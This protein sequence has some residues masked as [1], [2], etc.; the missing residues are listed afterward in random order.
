MENIFVN[1]SDLDNDEYNINLDF[2]RIK[3]KKTAII[4]EDYYYRRNFKVGDIVTIGCETD[5]GYVYCL[6][7]NEVKVNWGFVN[8]WET[9]YNL[10]IIPVEYGRD[11]LE[12][13]CSNNRICV[14]YEPYLDGWY[15]YI[16]GYLDNSDVEKSCL[17][18]NNNKFNKVDFVKYSYEKQILVDEKL[19]RKLY[20]YRDFKRYS[21]YKT[22]LFV[23]DGFDRYKKAFYILDKITKEVYF[24]GIKDDVRR[25]LG[26][27]Y[28]FYNDEK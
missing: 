4:Y 10:L 21:L 1:G 20:L 28:S 5:F 13:V 2:D 9:K 17:T 27:L 7:D 6:S 22:R 11:C 8:E 25:T 18:L 3:G 19:N 12:V 26:I 14:E 24:G 15:R 16:N 23:G